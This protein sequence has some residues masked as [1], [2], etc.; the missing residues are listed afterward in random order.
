MQEF[1]IA[2]DV[3]ANWAGY[4]VFIKIEDDKS[5]TDGF[6]AI[7][8]IKYYGLPDGCVDLVKDGSGNV[9]WTDYTEETAMFPT[10]GF[11][12][13]EG[14]SR[15]A[16]TGAFSY[17]YRASTN[18]ACESG[19][20][21]TFFYGAGTTGSCQYAKCPLGSITTTSASCAG[22]TSQ[23][24]FPT[25]ASVGTWP[26]NCPCVSSGALVYHREKGKRVCLS[27]SSPSQADCLQAAQNVEKTS[28]AASFV[29]TAVSTV[30]V[31]ARPKG[32][33][34]KVVDGAWE[35][36]YNTHS[37]GGHSSLDADGAPLYQAVC[38]GA[39]GA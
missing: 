26:E 19:S 8:T 28:G 25:S 36:Y 33:G 1:S 39:P 23:C 13:G 12:T 37:T 9:L 2:A 4:D 11:G 38:T 6:L 7:D 18:V 17:A 35:A 32:C 27:G 15:S 5:G 24:V 30:D 31:D 10:G 20:G 16:S 21:D 22:P 34:V 29:I 14:W 3:L